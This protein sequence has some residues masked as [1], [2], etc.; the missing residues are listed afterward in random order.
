[1]QITRRNTID[2]S[3][4]KKNDIRGIA[5]KSLSSELYTDLGK[6]YAKLILDRKIHAGNPVS[7]IWVS[8]GWDARLTSPEFAKALIKGLIE[9]EINVICLGLCPTPLAYFSEFLDNKKYEIPE[10][11]GSL[12]I[13]AS[14]NP[15]EYNGLK[16]TLNKTSLKE[17]EII[18]IKELI[19]SENFSCSNSIKG[20]VINFDITNSYIDLLKEQF[21]NIGNNLKIVVDSG[22]ATAGI[23]APELYRKIGCEVIELFSE[24]DGK[25]PNH[26]PDPLKEENLSF[27]K[28]KVLETR[29][30]FG[31]AFDGDSD[32]ICIV[33]DTG[34]SMQGDQLLLILALD[35]LSDKADS[36]EKIKI[37]S[38]VKCS[39]VL[40]DEINKNGGQSIM[41]KTGHS[42]I[43]SKMKEEN[44]LLA[45][46]MSGHLF[47]NDRYFGYDDAIYAGC[48]FI[49]VIHNKRLKDS[50]IKVSDVISKF[51]KTYASPEIRIE[52][53]D[54]LK[55]KIVDDLQEQIGKKLNLLG[56]NIKEIITIDGI[57]V[58]FEDG[59]GLIRA[60]NTEPSFTLRF[61]ANNESFLHK[62]Q[63]DMTKILKLEINLQQTKI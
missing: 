48:R 12:I 52:C 61:E 39:Q 26:H 32:R 27:L 20:K 2:E 34:K 49:E 19:K 6:A 38:E 44:A 5:E 13:T 55:F 8:V 46:E 63:F 37:I 11:T 29:A 17:E 51:R 45:G 36:P 10:I 62:L 47:F 33:D 23:V 9:S 3:I 58:V 31:I 50:K 21:K 16:F 53:P 59:F 54:N 22:N 60:S 42:F 40:Y 25:F 24:P 57:R 28:A 1:M 30:D 35:I 41:W 7:N 4:F 14:H 43:K 15:A 18:L 56:Y